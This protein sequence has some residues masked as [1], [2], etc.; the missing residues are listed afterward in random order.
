MNGEAREEKKF[1]AKKGDSLRVV[2]VGIHAEGQQVYLMSEANRTKFQK[3]QASGDSL[4][5]MECTG[6]TKLTTDK[7]KWLTTI[8]SDG[9]WYL[10]YDPHFSATLGFDLNADDVDLKK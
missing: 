8:P 3:N 10:T 9:T 2:A 1:T 7:P 4:V 5:A 6:M